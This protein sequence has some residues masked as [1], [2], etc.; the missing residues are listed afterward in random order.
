[1]SPTATLV[2][3]VPTAVTSPVASCPSTRSLTRGLCI[4]C[5]CEWQMPLENRRTTTCRGPGSGSCTCSM[6]RGASSWG[7]I[8]TRAGVGMMRLFLPVDKRCGDASRQA[9]GRLRR[10]EVMTR[11]GSRECPARRLG[12][13]ALGLR[14]DP[15]RPRLRR[16]LARPS[17]RDRASRLAGHRPR[18]GSRRAACRG[19]ALRQ[20]AGA[21]RG[22]Q[23]AVR[24]RRCSAAAA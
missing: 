18:H 9:G 3:S 5:S 17:L 24:R 4:R 23:H 22:A 7:R 2:T 16:W 13:A 10:V 21:R 1:M 15:A 11:S 6:A 20:T 14:A 12:R 19:A 8:T